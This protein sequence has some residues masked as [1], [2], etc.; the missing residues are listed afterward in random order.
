M[1]SGFCDVAKQTWTGKEMGRRNEL[2]LK[3]NIFLTKSWNQNY[4]C[5]MLLGV[6]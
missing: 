1:R 4:K 6:Y 2:I 5:Q 3:D